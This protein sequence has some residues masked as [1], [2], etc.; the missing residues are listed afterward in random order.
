MAITKNLF[1]DQGSTFLF[2]T[3]VTNSLGNAINISTGYTAAAKMKRSYYSS[4][5]ITFAASITGST[6]NIQISLTPTQTKDLKPGRYVYDIELQYP[7]GTITRIIQGQIHV[8]PEVT[9]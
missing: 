3:I 7:D 4:Q 8:D 5:G 2:S 9:R 1:L 6:G